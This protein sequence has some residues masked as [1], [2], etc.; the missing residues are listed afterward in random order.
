MGFGL[1]VKQKELFENVTFF[2]HYLTEM[3]N[4]NDNL[5]AVLSGKLT[6]TLSSNISGLTSL[7]AHT[8]VMLGCPH[9]LFWVP[10]WPYRVCAC[11]Y[12]IHSYPY[13]VFKEVE[14][15]LVSAC[16]LFLFHVI[17]FRIY[18]T[19]YFLL[20]L[21]QC[22]SMPRWINRVSSYPN[23]VD[24]GLF[25]SITGMSQRFEKVNNLHRD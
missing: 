21:I 12:F 19:F 14:T 3:L 9:T 23:R 18:L 2:H 24:C 15:L 10:I 7:M 5:L 6:Q 16:V 4:Q 25:L 1:L 22:F 20:V 13:I 17:I 8:H 11:V